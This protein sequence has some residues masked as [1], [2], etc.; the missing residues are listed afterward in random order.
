MASLESLALDIC[1]QVSNISNILAA[2][3]APSPSFNENSFA[4]F[5]G[6]RDISDLKLRNARNALINAAHDII[7]LASGPTDHILSLA[8]SVLSTKNDKP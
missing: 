4:D 1:S 6:P 5:E 8:F 2:H 3:S 7:R